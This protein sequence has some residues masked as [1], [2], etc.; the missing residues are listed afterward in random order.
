MNTP[1]TIKAIAKANAESALQAEREVATA[2]A[3]KYD[4]LKAAAAALVTA[5]GEDD[6]T[7]D[8]CSDEIEA[9]EALV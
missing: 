3:A 5:L 8:G 4:A 6:A 7:I 2:L 9:V 1:T